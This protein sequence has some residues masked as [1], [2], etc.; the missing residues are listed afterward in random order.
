MA[1]FTQLLALRYKGKIDSDAYKFIEQAVNGAVR[2]RGLIEDLLV[3]SRVTP[4]RNDFR[5]TDCGAVIR[6]RPSWVTPR[7][8][9][10]FFKTC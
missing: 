4:D 5:P 2:M 8:W 7:G 6:C 3:Y 10:S 9:N 1:S